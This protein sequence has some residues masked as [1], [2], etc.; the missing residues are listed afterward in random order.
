MAASSVFTCLS[1]Q[2]PLGLRD[3]DI[4]FPASRLQTLGN[5]ASLAKPSLSW[6]RGWGSHFVVLNWIMSG[7]YL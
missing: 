6:E 5:L 7:G 2:A 1:F 3:R 4:T